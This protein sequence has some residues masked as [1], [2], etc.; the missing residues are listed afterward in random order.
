MPSI[1]ENV[2]T[3]ISPY[4]PHILQS[5]WKCAV[6]CNNCMCRNCLLVRDI[7]QKKKPCL[8]ECSAEEEREK[9][10]EGGKVCKG[11]YMS[12]CACTY[13]RLIPC[14]AAWAVFCF[15]SQALLVPPCSREQ[16]GTPPELNAYGSAEPSDASLKKKWHAKLASDV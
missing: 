3:A 2:F 7:L 8:A 12:T 14:G 10:K 16:W 4:I 13:A 15:K 9:E 11:L 5:P 1:N 6:T